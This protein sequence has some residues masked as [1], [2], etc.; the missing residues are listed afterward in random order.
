MLLNKTQTLIHNDFRIR[1]F[2]SMHVEVKK[3]K[4]NSH[5]AIVL[6]SPVCHHCQVLTP[7]VKPH[8]NSASSETIK[9]CLL[10]FCCFLTKFV[11]STG[12]SQN[13]PRISCFLSAKNNNIFS[14]HFCNA[15]IH[16]STNTI[17]NPPFLLNRFIWARLSLCITIKIFPDY[18]FPGHPKKCDKKIEL[19][20][21]HL[22]LILTIT[23]P[24]KSEWVVHTQ[25]AYGSIHT[26][27]FIH[28]L[29]TFTQHML[30]YTHA[31]LAH[32]HRG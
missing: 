24:R 6:S 28:A 17:Y 32:L 12:F 4:K 5:P 2:F 1:F 21:G 30:T 11:L 19:L 16:F 3:K 14:S 9:L 18:M 15:L 26:H 7:M 8:L 13:N 25:N 20:S 10:T 22:G 27:T 29:S 23:Y 31:W